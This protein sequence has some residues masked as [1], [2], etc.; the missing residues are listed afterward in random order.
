MTQ[1]RQHWHEHPMAGSLHPAEPRWRLRI[2]V[3]S[4]PA[5]VFFAV[6]KG[7]DELPPPS[8][9]KVLEASPTPMAAGVRYG[10]RVVPLGRVFRL[11]R[12]FLRGHTIPL[13]GP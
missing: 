3:V 11:P 5:G 12:P 4:P 10:F 2:R 8:P 9:H 1:R 6:R 13:F 7:K